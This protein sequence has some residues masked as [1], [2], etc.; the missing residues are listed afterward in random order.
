[1]EHLSYITAPE[2]MIRSDCNEYRSALN[3]AFLVPLKGNAF[4]K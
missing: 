2:L 4:D 1:M 3:A